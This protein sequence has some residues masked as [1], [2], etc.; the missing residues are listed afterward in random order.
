MHN[1]NAIS[2]L[3]CPFPMDIIVNLKIINNVDQLLRAKRSGKVC[4]DHL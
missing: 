1:W 2:K 4:M 3:Q